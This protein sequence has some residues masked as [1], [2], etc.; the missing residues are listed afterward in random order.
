MGCYNGTCGA[1]QL[2]I[3]SG[4]PVVFFFLTKVPT[5]EDGSGFCSPN[6]IWT[7]RSLPVFAIYD[8]YGS[9]EGYKKNWNTEF[10]VNKFKEDA[11]PMEVGENKSR[12]LAVIPGNLTFE[13]I[14][15]LIHLNRLYVKG[16]NP[17]LNK[18][19][20]NVGFMMVHKFVWD[21]FV[22]SA[23]DSIFGDITIEQV[24]KDGNE[25]V[26]YLLENQSKNSNIIN[27]SRFEIRN[28]RNVFSHIVSRSNGL[29]NVLIFGGIRDYLQMLENDF[30]ERKYCSKKSEK[31]IRS[32]SEVY[33]FNYGMKITRKHYSPQSGAGSQDADYEAYEN[34]LNAT[35]AHIDR[36]KKELEW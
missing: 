34:L 36:K 30:Y 1:T 27:W 3:H 6:S 5:D 18:D 11:V 26:N 28:P 22:N 29:N 2:P 20:T 19:R 21:H 13:S 12:D 17:C 10:I 7:L 35:Y 14:L 32:V 23:F 16:V 25:W 9:I 15:E 4:D 31:I 8:D 24:I 33:M